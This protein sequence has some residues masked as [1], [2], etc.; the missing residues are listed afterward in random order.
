MQQHVEQT[1][2]DCI[3]VIHT[4][5][6]KGLVGFI[7]PYTHT[8]IKIFFQITDYYILKEC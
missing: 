6:T 2:Y 7:I 3:R 8:G 4:E 1:T 5:G